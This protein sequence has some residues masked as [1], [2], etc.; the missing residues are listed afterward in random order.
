[1]LIFNP[2]KNTNENRSACAG[3]WWVGIAE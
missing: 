1:V 2:T 3:A